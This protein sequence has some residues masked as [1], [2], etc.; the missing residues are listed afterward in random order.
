MLKSTKEKKKFQ[1][2]DYKYMTEESV[3]EDDDDVIR[4]HKLQWRSDSKPVWPYNFNKNSLIL[5]LYHLSYRT[6]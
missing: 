2:I 4:T 3:S 5:I 6:Q 1:Q